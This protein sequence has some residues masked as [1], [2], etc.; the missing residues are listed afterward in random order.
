MPRQTKLVCVLLAAHRLSCCRRSLVPHGASCPSSHWSS[1]VNLS[2]L[3]DGGKTLSV[4]TYPLILCTSCLFVWSYLNS[5]IIIVL[6]KTSSLKFNW[7]PPLLAA[8]CSPP[9]QGQ[10]E[11]QGSLAL[12]FWCK[13]WPSAVAK[14]RHPAGK[15]FLKSRC[16]I[17]R[18]W[19]RLYPGGSWHSYRETRKHLYIFH[20]HRRLTSTAGKSTF[21]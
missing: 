6:F 11:S 7:I 4:D 14:S 21:P 15:N 3:I 13:G 20:F 8:V 17:C 18:L 5:N 1:L 2:L 16:F 10:D 12:D 9:S 19:R